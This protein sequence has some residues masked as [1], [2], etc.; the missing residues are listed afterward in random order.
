MYILHAVR[1]HKFTSIVDWL[2]L[3][4]VKFGQNCDL[5]VNSDLMVKIGQNVSSK[6][7]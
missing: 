3:K 7:T 6:V 2:D 1:N 5:I 4:S